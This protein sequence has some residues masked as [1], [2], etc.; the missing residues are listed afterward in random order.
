[1][2]EEPVLPPVGVHE[3]IERLGRA[4]Q[5]IEPGSLGNIQPVVIENIQRVA[6]IHI[7]ENDEIVGVESADV[8]SEA[9]CS[10]EEFLDGELREQLEAGGDD[11]GAPAGGA[12]LSFRD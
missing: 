5:Q 9:V 3:T 7:L 4:A 6:V 1:M 2:I 10:L 12:T 11:A 8:G